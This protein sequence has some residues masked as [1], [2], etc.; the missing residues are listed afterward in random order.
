MVQPHRLAAGQRPKGQLR[1]NPERQSAGFL[2][3]GMNVE[4]LTLKFLGF[5]VFAHL[6]LNPGLGTGLRKHLPHKESFVLIFD[7]MPAELDIDIREAHS[8]AH[9][10]VIFLLP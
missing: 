9:H 7:L 2:R 10:A 3:G 4:D 5:I 8:L 1:N 6:A